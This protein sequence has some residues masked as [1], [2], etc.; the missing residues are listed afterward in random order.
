MTFFSDLSRRA[1]W[2]EPKRGPLYLQLSRH[3]EAAI[4]SGE[5]AGNSS[6]PSER[7]MAL[8]TGLSRVTIRK[9]IEVLASQKL[10]DQRR[11]SGNFIL[12]PQE[13]LDYSLSHLTSFTDQMQRR[14]KTSGSEVISAELGLPSPEEMVILGL[15]TDEMVARVKRLRRA[16]GMPM[17]IE[18]SALPPDILPDPKAVSVSLYK[19]LSEQKTKP[20]RAMQRISATR[21]TPQQAKLLE[22]DINDPALKVV[23][24]G[25]LSSGRIV[26]FTTGVYRGDAYDFVAELKL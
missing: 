9:A 24:T 23:R 5:L 6:L 19:I 17:A 4:R 11:G 25:Y 21:L 1:E 18:I 20:V 13:D 22:V 2:L 16:D 12:S 14:G 7:E 26:E 10:I 3:I 15:G 8:F